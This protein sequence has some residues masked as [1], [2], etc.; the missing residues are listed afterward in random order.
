ML[1]SD[2]TST[3]AANASRIAGRKAGIE[4]KFFTMY[5]LLKAWSV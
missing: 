4:R 5:D 3:S 2:G 1:T